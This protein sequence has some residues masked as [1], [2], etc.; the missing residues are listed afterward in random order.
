MFICDSGRVVEPHRF[1]NRSPPIL[2]LNVGKVKFN[3]ERNES[4]APS[5]KDL[6]FLLLVGKQQ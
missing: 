1:I 4:V 5:V 3:I 2:L 6:P